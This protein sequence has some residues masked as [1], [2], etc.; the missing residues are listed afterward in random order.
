MRDA[1]VEAA[2]VEQGAGLVGVVVGVQ[3]DGDVVGQ[4][5]QVVQAVQGRGEQWGVVAVGAGQDVTQG[6]P[7]PSVMP[8]RSGPV[9]RGRPG[10]ARPPRRLRRK[11]GERDSDREIVELFLAARNAR[12][13]F[14]VLPRDH[15]G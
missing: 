12:D 10:N 5:T 13:R 4:R 3:V 2:F 11:K 14:I 6:V 7:Y 9:C 15:R 1:A 8:E